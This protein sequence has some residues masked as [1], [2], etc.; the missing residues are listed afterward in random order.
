M[1]ILIVEDDASV[2]E[3]CRRV[4]ADEGYDCVVAR[5]AIAARAAVARCPIDLLLA[6]V[7]L[8]GD[9]SGADLA[10]EMDGGRPG[11]LMMSGDDIALRRLAA[12]GIAYLEKPFRI[13]ELISHVQA[14]LNPIP[15]RPQ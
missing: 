2:A 9:S 10:A 6:D 5:D 15:G 8:P 13:P 4:L 11:I 3:L 14:A 1:R 12:A 7:V